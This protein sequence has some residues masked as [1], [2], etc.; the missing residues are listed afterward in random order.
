MTEFLWTSGC[1]QQIITRYTSSMPSY[2]DSLGEKSKRERKSTR[3][4][5]Y[6]T[7][8]SDKLFLSREG[9]ADLGEIPHTFPT[10]DKI[11]EP[12]NPISA[13]TTMDDTK[14]PHTGDHATTT[15]CSHLKVCQCPRWT[16]PPPR[17][18]SVHIPATEANRE[19]LQQYLLD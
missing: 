13:A 19:S 9:C 10:M 18:T 1:M 4:I 7:A 17:P 16:Q 8:C 15:N 2:C 3:Q 11:I 12:D 6:V 14:E 5:V